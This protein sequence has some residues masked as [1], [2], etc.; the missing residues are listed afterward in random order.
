MNRSLSEASRAT[1]KMALAATDMLFGVAAMHTLGIVLH[2][3][4]LARIA[5][6]PPRFLNPLIHP[7]I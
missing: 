3:L 2:W 5:T 7:M 6:S 4:L 1:E